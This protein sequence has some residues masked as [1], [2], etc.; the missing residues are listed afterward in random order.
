MQGKEDSGRNVR[1][2]PSLAANAKRIGIEA[3]IL[4]AAAIA[5]YLLL[6]QFV[7]AHLSAGLSA[8]IALALYLF[9]AWLGY[10]LVRRYTAVV[11]AWRTQQIASEEEL[12]MLRTVIDSLPDLIYVKDRQNRFLMANPQLRTHAATLAV[13]PAMAVEMP[14]EPPAT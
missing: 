2:E 6:A 11:R 7:F 8:L 12:R 5:A 4:A 3:A 13:A 10:L 14:R 9:L 1:A